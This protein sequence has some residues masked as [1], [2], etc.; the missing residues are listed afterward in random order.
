[1]QN[2]DEESDN[3]TTAG[4]VLVDQKGRMLTLVVKTDYESFF[5]SLSPME[6]IASPQS[7]NSVPSIYSGDFWLTDIDI[8]GE[9]KLWVTDADG[10][11]HTN[12]TGEWSI[13]SV[14]SEALTVIKCL[15]DG[16]VLAGG[17]SSEVFV[18]SDDGWDRMGDVLRARINDIA[19]MSS[20][21]VAVVGDGG[22]L[23][24]FDGNVWTEVALATNVKLNGIV[25]LR[26]Q[27]FL[28]CGDRGALF[29]GR[30]NEFLA[31]P[32]VDEK[33]FKLIYWNDEI[34]CACGTGGAGRLDQ[35]FNLEIMRNTF[36]AF[37]LHSS[38]GFIS[39]AGHDIVVR[40]DGKKWAG[41]KYR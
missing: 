21:N 29:V 30:D 41:F 5:S 16:T 6:D 27:R 1:M 15:T 25:A 14:S 11:V 4:G 31:L 33:M 13:E 8:D 34:W 32:P 17:T 3:T 40:F 36:A 10:R 24:T 12:L 7:T 35:E 18:R 23:A 2:S 38:G 19:G 20:K 28:A 39:F 26:D 9:G 22:F 37:R